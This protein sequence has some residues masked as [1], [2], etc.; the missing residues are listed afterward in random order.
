MEFPRVFGLFVAQ[1]DDGIDASRASRGDV[2]RGQSNQRQKQRNGGERKRVCSAD[3]VEQCGHEPSDDERSHDSE[4][5][6]EKRESR[7]LA[8]DEA[9]DVAAIRAK[10]HADAE[11]LG[12][13]RDAVSDHAVDAD[14][15]EHQS[16]CGKY[17]EHKR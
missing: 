1:G 13:L 6:A 10:G 8:K 9:E 16:K 14:A 3:T 11:F 12:A 2:A 7:P 17:S 15:R 4:A 5:D